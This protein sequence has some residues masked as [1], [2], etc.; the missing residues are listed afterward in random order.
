MCVSTP[1]D[2]LDGLFIHVLM[3]ALQTTRMG[4]NLMIVRAHVGKANLVFM[5]SHLESTMV[6]FDKNNLSA[7]N[8]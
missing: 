7:F 5:N 1:K 6:K 3:L 8:G 4:R 2:D